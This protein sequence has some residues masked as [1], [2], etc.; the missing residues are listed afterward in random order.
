MEAQVRILSPQM[1]EDDLREWL[2]QEVNGLYKTLEAGEITKAAFV[3]R[4]WVSEYSSY[5][6]R[7]LLLLHWEHT[8]SEMLYKLQ[9]HEGGVWCGGAA[10]LFSSLL[11]LAHIPAAVYMYGE[12]DLSH[13]TTVFG[14]KQGKYFRFYLLDAYLNFHYTHPDGKLMNL[15]ELFYRV[16][17]KQYDQIVRVDVPIARKLVTADRD[18]QYYSWLFPDGAPEEPDFEAGDHKVYKGAVH[19]VSELLLP[20]SPF[21]KLADQERGAQPLEEFMLDLMLVHPT[22]GRMYNTNYPEIALYQGVVEALT[23]K[24]AT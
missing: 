10:W 13:E 14:V 1:D 11:Q 4:Q 21:R 18:A 16:R 9:K 22:F 24:E 3:L 15:E 12:G 19:S 2:Y 20:S 23:R 17:Q 6:Q 5:P 8:L 7:E